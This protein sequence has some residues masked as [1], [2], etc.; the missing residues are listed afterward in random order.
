MSASTFRHRKRHWN[1]GGIS[2]LKKLW[3]EW[4]G[5]DFDL[6]SAPGA[7]LF[8]IGAKPKEEAKPPAPGSVLAASPPAHAASSAPAPKPPVVVKHYPPAAEAKEAEEAKESKEGGGGGHETPKPKAKEASSKLGAITP[9]AK[10][11]VT[12]TAERPSNERLL[13]VMTEAQRQRIEKAPEEERE[14]LFTKF[15]EK[16]K[17]MIGAVAGGLK[18]AATATG[19]QAEPEAAAAAAPPPPPP[20][21]A[22][23]AEAP[24]PAHAA[25]LEGKKLHGT[26]NGK[27]V[28]AGNKGGLYTIN[29]KGKL[30]SIKQAD[31]KNVKTNK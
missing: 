10:K 6:S 8:G 7:Y 16:I 24:A 14:S 15:Y 19:A 1:Q 27:P 26:L 2:E 31:R 21:P 5:D 30:D 9:A 3:E 4:D 23:A 13:E 28:Y 29:S 12:E 17:S 11:L 22:P 18:G 25:T 20:P